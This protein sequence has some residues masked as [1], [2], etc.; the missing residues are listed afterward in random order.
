[1]TA[2]ML[3]PGRSGSRLLL[4]IESSGKQG[5]ARVEE[6]WQDNLGDEGELKS[7]MPDFQ[8]GDDQEATKANKHDGSM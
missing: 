7:W 2:G 6:A 4:R 3:T 8:M 5:R 1:M